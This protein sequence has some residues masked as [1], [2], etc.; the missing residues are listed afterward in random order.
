[1]KYTDFFLTASQVQPSPGY[2]LD[3]AH[4]RERVNR[5]AISRFL[6]CLGSKQPRDIEAEVLAWW[7]KT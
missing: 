3:Q 7:A 5:R 4:R 1:M 2:G 6:R